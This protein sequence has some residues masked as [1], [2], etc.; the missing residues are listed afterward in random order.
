[1]A[2]SR[3][4]PQFVEVCL[5]RELREGE[6]MPCPRCGH[7]NVDYRSHRSW[8]WIA[9]G[10]G[11]LALILLGLKM[12]SAGGVLGTAALLLAGVLLSDEPRYVCRHCG[13]SWRHRDAV[14]WAT[15]IRHDL[16]RDRKQGSA[17]G[18]V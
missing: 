10:M 2:T 9:V 16:G 18:L 17:S 6:P 14:K 7:D 12:T 3:F 15:A 4:S 1:M 11:V 5:E 8:L 13:H